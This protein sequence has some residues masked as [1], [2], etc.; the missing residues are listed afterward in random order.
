MAAKRFPSLFQCTAD[1]DFVPVGN[2]FLKS[3]QVFFQCTRMS[4]M[5]STELCH[6]LRIAVFLRI[7]LDFS[8][9]DVY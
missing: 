8:V 2:I 9:F 5:R 4:D 6:S 3:W 7:D 1:T